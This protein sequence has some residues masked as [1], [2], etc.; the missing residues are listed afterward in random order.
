MACSFGAILNCDGCS[1]GKF[2]QSSA[3]LVADNRK[4]LK[5]KK[6]LP[7][8]GVRCPTEASWSLKTPVIQPFYKISFTLKAQSSSATLSR[9]VPGLLEAF[10]ISEWLYQGA[11]LQGADG[12]LWI[13]DLAWW[14]GRYVYIFKP[15]L[16]ISSI[17]RWTEIKLSWR[18]GLNSNLGA[19][20]S[21]I[22][23]ISNW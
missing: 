21:L 15:S 23:R 3:Q 11:G 6:M 18:A 19:K 4:I 5:D 13:A 7:R 2:I 10:P 8:G 20:P 1:A 9:V 17:K 14:I 22:V 12:V 16:F